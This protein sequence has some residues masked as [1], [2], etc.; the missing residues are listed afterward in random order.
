MK[1]I[2]FLLY[3]VVAVI[4][5]SITSCSPKS[6]LSVEEHALV[7][8]DWEGESLVFEP[9]EGSREEILAKHA[10]ER[11]KSPITYMLPVNLG[12]DTL[13]VMEK[14]TDNLVSVEVYRNDLLE[15][16]I[17]AGVIS[18]INNFRGLWLDEGHWFLEVAHVEEDPV[19]PN[20]AFIIWGEIFQDGES[21][22]EKFGYGE[23]FNFQILNGEPFFFFSEDGEIGFSYDGEETALRYSDIPH[24]QCCSGAAF[25]P[26]PAEKMVSFY[27]TKEVV[28]YYVE[29]GA[30]K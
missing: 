12:S 22:N 3:V 26:L 14:Y 10:D 24:Y 29:I 15:V 28:R 8:M 11:S 7:A 25:N 30:F 17:D 9:I 6:K 19:D 18:P 23:A 1:K 20:A 27:A 16:S 2:F 21:L 4:C 5:I 13:N